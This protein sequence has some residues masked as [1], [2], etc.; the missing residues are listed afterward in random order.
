[1]RAS[2]SVPLYHATRARF[3]VSLAVCFPLSS[4]FVRVSVEL[5]IHPSTLVGVYATLPSPA[6]ILTLFE[7]A[8]E[9]AEG[10]EGGWLFN[11]NLSTAPIVAGYVAGEAAD[12]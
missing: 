2:S 7:S 3:S 11:S 4:R 1:M 6:H 10:E 9:T 8:A 5:S 12:N